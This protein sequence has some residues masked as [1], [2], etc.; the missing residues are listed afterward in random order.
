MQKGSKLVYGWG[1]NDVGY[2][3]QIKENLPKVNG[4]QKQ[5]LI[6]R[7]PYYKTWMNMLTRVHSTSYKSRNKSYLDCT[8]CEE[9]KYFSNFIKWVD[10]QPNRDWQNCDLD[11][12]LLSRSARHYSPENCCFIP[13]VLNRFLTTLS[14]DNRGELLLG[15]T[16]YKYN[17]TKKYRALCSNPFT[18]KNTWLGSYEYELEAHKAWQDKKHEYACLLAEQQQDPRVAKALRERYAP[19][20]D[21]TDN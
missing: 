10:Y 7:C 9:W 15:V 20:K 16:S 11:K 5:K 21:W 3:V 6:W 18:G 12:D 14:V 1:V 8:I 19:D 2:P 13:K 4:K 17:K